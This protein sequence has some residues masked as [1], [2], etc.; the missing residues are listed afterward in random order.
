MWFDAV[1]LAWSSLMCVAMSIRSLGATSKAGGV[2]IL[3][4][5]LRRGDEKRYSI[6][7]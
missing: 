5:P 3:Q 2:A 6:C 7:G 4:I 1:E